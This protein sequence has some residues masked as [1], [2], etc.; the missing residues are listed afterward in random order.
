MHGPTRP[1]IMA[2]QRATMQRFWLSLHEHPGGVT[3]T[4]GNRVVYDL[5]ENVAHYGAATV[6]GPALVWELEPGK[7]MGKAAAGKLE[8]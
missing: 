1:N 6:A 8:G 3:T 7:A 4:A 2:Q 5:T